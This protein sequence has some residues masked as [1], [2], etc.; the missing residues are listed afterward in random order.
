MPAQL[1]EGIMAD[2][3]NN[4]GPQDRNRI[5]LEGRHEVAYWTKALGIDEA[6]LK[7]LVARVGN[8]AAAVK[9][10]LGK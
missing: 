4:R 6:A 7:Q 1:W 8:N 3:L 10:A 9:A 5:S 2:D